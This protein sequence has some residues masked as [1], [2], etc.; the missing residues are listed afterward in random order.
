MMIQH[1]CVLHLGQNAT[2][3]AYIS[4]T[5]G[6]ER[7]CVAVVAPKVVDHMAAD[8]LD[9]HGIQLMQ[10]SDARRAPRRPPIAVSFIHMVA[11]QRIRVKFRIIM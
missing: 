10:R 7:Q 5:V 11:W 9:A 8:V 6:L 1:S 3:T 2:A 4:H